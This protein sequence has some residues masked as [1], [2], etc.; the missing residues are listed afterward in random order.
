MA[1]DDKKKH[2]LERKVQGGNKAC[3]DECQ[4]DETTVQTATNAK[5]PPE[6]STWLVTSR[7][8][9]R[10]VE[11]TGLNQTRWLRVASEAKQLV[12]REKAAT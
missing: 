6:V 4:R 12:T 3:A 10:M 2:V 5:I 1:K 8:L 9:P 11:A 7:Q